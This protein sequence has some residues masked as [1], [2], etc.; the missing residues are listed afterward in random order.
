MKYMNGSIK[1]EDIASEN[2]TRM[3]IAK[4]HRGR[5]SMFVVCAITAADHTAVDES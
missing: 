2:I 1:V 4:V 3:R 5:R